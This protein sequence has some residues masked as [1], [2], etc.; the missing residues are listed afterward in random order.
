MESCIKNLPEKGD[1]FS[2]YER[3]ITVIKADALKNWQNIVM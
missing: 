1:L 2:K 3:D